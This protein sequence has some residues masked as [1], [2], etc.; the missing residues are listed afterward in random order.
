M[1][2]VVVG[3]MLSTSC[4]MMFF[5]VLLGLM[6]CCLLALEALWTPCYVSVRMEPSVPQTHMRCG[7]GP[8][9]MERDVQKSLGS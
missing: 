3:T 9:T 4:C 6:E 1:T 7:T 5:T 8:V 2:H